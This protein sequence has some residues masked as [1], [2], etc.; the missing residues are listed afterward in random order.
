MP[1]LKK[2]ITD[3]L[4]THNLNFCYLSHSI[5][6]DIVLMC[7]SCKN[8]IKVKWATLRRKKTSFN[9]KNCNEIDEIL[10]DYK[11]LNIGVSNKIYQNRGDDNRIRWFIDF[12]CPK[13]HINQNVRWEN[14]K[15]RKTCPQCNYDVTTWNNEEIKKL[16]AKNI[17]KLSLESILPPSSNANTKL[18]VKDTFGYIYETTPHLINQNNKSNR[19]LNPF[20]YKRYKSNNLEIWIKLNRPDYEFAVDYNL[21]NKANSKTSIK[22]KYIGDQLPED[23]DPFFNC[24]LAKFKA[25]QN[26]PF[27]KYSSSGEMLL[28]K[29]L[30]ELDLSYKPQYEINYKEQNLYFDFAILDNE[31]QPILFIEFNGK[32]HYKNVKYFGGEKSLIKQQNNDQKKVEYAEKHSVR[33]LVFKEKN[34]EKMKMEIENTLGNN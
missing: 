12:T 26:H 22:M 6:S 20:L 5:N 10:K 33:L 9:C 14:L 24:S 4:S 16:L 2:N 11:K 1:L 3:F 13:G 30:Y 27:F 29:I 19:K 7:V 25:G 28:S 31:Q 32:Q 15:I 21:L 18:V 34:I 17:N 8:E 23:A